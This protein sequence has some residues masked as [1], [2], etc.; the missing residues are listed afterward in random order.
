MDELNNF[1]EKNLLITGGLGFI[2]SSA[3]CLQYVLNGWNT[4]GYRNS[5][6]S[7]SKLTDVTGADRPRSAAGLQANYPVYG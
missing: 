1:S 7:N 5:L 2:G 4:G 6:Q 3:P